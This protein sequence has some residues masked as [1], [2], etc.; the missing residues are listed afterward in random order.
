MRHTYPI[1]TLKSLFRIH[2]NIIL[3]STLMPFKVG[4]LLVFR[5][6]FCT[7]LSCC[8][9]SQRPSPKHSQ[10]MHVLPLLYDGNTGT[11]ITSVELAME[12]STR[13]T[14]LHRNML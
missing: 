13:H 4:S 11:I 12:A 10:P 5:L 14:K 8:Q 9:Y 7:R 1:R 3:S 6:K 2:F